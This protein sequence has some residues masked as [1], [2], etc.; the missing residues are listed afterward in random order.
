MPRSA[1]NG[2]P[3]SP[4]C[5]AAYM[6]WQ[7]VSTIR[8][9]PLSAARRKRG[10]APNSPSETA[11]AL[12][13]GHA[14]GADQEVDLEARSGAGTR[15]GG[16]WRRGGPAPAG[17]PIEAPASGFG[18]A[19]RQPSSISRASSSMEVCDTM[20]RHIAARRAG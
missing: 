1:T 13:R 4:A 11:A 19:S 5:T 17:P 10:A 8:T 3:F 12:D 9:V 18:S 6:A 2:L 15:A 16:R 14:A 20:G 7:V